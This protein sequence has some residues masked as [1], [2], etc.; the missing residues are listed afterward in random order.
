MSISSYVNPELV[1][2][3]RT[4]L[5]PRKT[6]FVAL[7][8]LSLAGVIA[9][10]AWL[11]NSRPYPD[12]PAQLERAAK[13]AFYGYNVVLVA[14]L[15]IIG[16]AMSGI[17]LVQERLRGTAIFQ[18]M[19][20][21]SPF[22]LA[23]GKLLGSSLLVYFAALIFSPFIVVSAI[24]ANLGLEQLIRIGI[25][26][27]FGGIFCQAVGLL[28]SAIVSAGGDRLVRGGL[29][30]GPLVGGVGLVTC[31]ITQSWFFFGGSY[32]PYYMLHFFGELSRGW[33]LLTVLFAVG[34]IWAF[35]L[36]VRQ[37]KASQFIN[38]SPWPV[39]L[40]FIT[41]ELAL[42]GLIWGYKGSGFDVQDIL[43]DAKSR[44]VVYV[45]INWAALLVMT[46]SYSL[47]VDRLREWWSAREDA[48]A[49][50][51]RKG[52]RQDIGTLLM[53]LL[54][55]LVGLAAIWYSLYATGELPGNEPFTGAGLL[56]IEACFV[57]TIIG[58]VAFVQ[59]C[60]MFKLRLG[61]WTGVVLAVA[62]YSILGVG[63]A[64]IG[65]SDNAVELTNPVSFASA[66][67][68]D[69]YYPKRFDLTVSNDRQGTP[70]RSS[71]MVTGLISEGLLA[72]FLV[73]LAW[74]KWTRMREGMIG[75][76]VEVAARAISEELSARIK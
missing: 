34:A 21:I 32:Y 49:I 23:M 4:S 75:E 56:S 68:T 27:I 13:D 25:F 74:V 48:H 18:Q 19:L 47:G 53:S 17:S 43:A 26:F 69:V 62:L 37:I 72:L 61:A 7:I 29:L 28:V 58:T 42:V 9:G 51:Y 22:E 59:F 71:I 67:T 12:A 73:G 6:I 39:W 63:G 11:S 3:F 65:P 46:A 50:F 57:F 15:F 54:I 70:D 14:L 60:A 24:L 36:T 30:V 41:A 38:L 8:A 66:L 2:S 33:V 64:L 45:L 52:V 10:L 20:L 31:V 1:K 76:S 44:L 16:P 35:A 40:L 55:A 5:S